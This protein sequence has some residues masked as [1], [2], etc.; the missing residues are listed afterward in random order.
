MHNKIAQMLFAL[1]TD[2]TIKEALAALKQG[3]KV[4]IGCYNTM[5]AF[6][7]VMLESGAVKVGDEVNM[8]FAQVL[9]K[10]ADS[11]RKYTVKQHNGDK[12]TRHVRVEEMP[13]NLQ[14]MW[15]SLIAMIDNTVTDVPAMPIDT[16]AKA[17]AK[18]GFKVGEITG[19]THVL[20]WTEEKNILRK[21][22]DKEKYDKATP[23]NDFNSGALDALIINSSGSTGISLHSSTTFKDQRPRHMILTQMSNE[24]NEAVQLL[25]RI[26]R[27]G[28]VNKPSYMIKIS[29]LPGEKRP[30]AILQKKLATLFA[31]VSGKGESA[32]SLEVNDIINQYGDRVIAEMFAD[33]PD[34]NERLSGVLDSKIRLDDHSFLDADRDGRIQQILRAFPEDGSLTKKVTGWASLQPVATQEEVWGT[35]D[36]GYEE[37]VENLKQLGEYN[38]ESEHLDLQAR[39]VART[40]LAVGDESG[41]SELSSPT[42][43]ESVDAKIQRKPMTAKEIMTRIDVH[44]KGKDPRALANEMKEQVEADFGPWL[45]DK[46]ALMRGAGNAPENIERF[47]QGARNALEFSLRH[48]DDYQIG[49]AVNY[50]LLNMTGVIYDIKYRPATGSNPATP[51]NLKITMAVDSTMRTF[52]TSMAGIGNTVRYTMSVQDGWLDGSPESPGWDDRVAALSTRPYERRYIVTGN[53]LGNPLDRGQMAYFTREGG[54]LTSGFVMPLNFDPSGYPELQTVSLNQDQAIRILRSEGTIT[55]GDVNLRTNPGPFTIVVPA[56]R[57]TGGKYYLNEK[58]LSHVE[59]GDFHKIGSSMQ[60]QIDGVEN[61]RAIVNLLYGDHSIVMQTPRATFERVIGVQQDGGHQPL[62]VA[63]SKDAYKAKTTA[64]LGRQIVPNPKVMAAHQAEEMRVAYGSESAAQEVVKKGMAQ[65]RRA[66]Q[67]QVS[68]A[69]VPGSVQDYRNKVAIEYGD[70][71]WV[72]LTGRRLTPGQEAYEIAQLFQIFRSPS[73]ENFH[74]I[75]TDDKGRILAHNMLSSGTLNSVN[76]GIAWL[77]SD[78]KSTAARLG[79]TRAHFMHNHPSGDPKMSFGDK[80]AFNS[81]YQGLP[82]VNLKGL[83]NLMGEFVVIDHGKLSYIANGMELGGYFKATPGMGDWL[84]KKVKVTDPA[85]LANFVASIRYEGDRTDTNKITLVFTN[86]KNQVQGWTVNRKELLTKPLAKVRETLMQMARAYDASQVSIILGDPN[87]MEGFLTQVARDTNGSLEGWVMDIQTPE[88]DS[89]R[90]EI[91]ELWKAGE[92]KS[93][94]A[95]TKGFLFEEKAEYDAQ[96]QADID[97]FREKHIAAQ[98]EEKKA[99]KD[100]L[101]EK[102]RTIYDQTIDR[103]GSW[104][105]AAERAARGGAMVPAGENIVNTL[106]YMRGVEGRVHQGT[107]GEWVYQDKKGFD[108]NLGMEVFTGDETG[109]QGAQPEG[110]P[111]RTQEAGRQAGGSYDEATKDLETFMVAQRD[112]EL[113]GETGTREAGEIKG[114][115]PEESNRVIGAIQRKYGQDFKDLMAVADSVREW[116]DEM[117][118]QPL[119]QAGFIDAETY[120]KIKDRNQ[121]Y[122]PYK[123]LLDDVESYIAANAAAIGVP[124]RVIKEIKGSERK[125]LD[126]LQMWIDLAHKA[127]YAYAKNRTIRSVYVTAKAAEWQDVKEIPA[128]YLP[129][130]FVQK[131]EV[132]SKLRPQLVGLANDLGIKVRMVAKMRGR[133]L[134]QFKSWINQEVKDGKLT[135]EMAKEI[136]VRFATFREHHGPRTRARH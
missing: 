6:L 68:G 1:R 34:L 75:Y 70:Q 31:N 43:F 104:E 18:E 73:Q 92:K 13:E 128:K 50:P 114:V 72:N 47:E 133:R 45:E 93:V 103:W 86:T 49:T 115:H 109:K 62:Q 8:N 21:R 16:I 111:G 65:A 46:L 55:G 117:I 76:M 79:A 98:P 52:K 126:P 90:R 41:K 97:A 24:I 4:V 64:T 36:A 100:R 105:R 14:A 85:A 27:T 129:V 10:A 77:L 35:I 66:V 3:K 119:L 60:A 124:G 80:M 28:Q 108:E 81:L 106:S 19:R 127:A 20:D 37:L 122:I 110:A 12:E 102:L 96:D 44:L 94:P 26:H 48:L 23:V 59:H 17:L 58:I 71:K 121:Y 107:M 120:A 9:R 74:V 89:I 39:P 82:D 87:V 57:K 69:A 91:P 130:D 38:L 25:G 15:H 30:L 95:L 136:T 84:S 134:G 61:L 78:V 125:V 53:L 116:G 54:E 51:G 83:G 22:S 40:I 29:S 112:L 56:A 132:D 101:T 131:Q 67:R 113:A 11:V 99:L 7:N 123:R 5:E 88:G 2:A 63:E 118:L 42:Y 135:Q 33:D 32:Y